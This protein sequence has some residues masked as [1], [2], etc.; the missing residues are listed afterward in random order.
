MD[1]LFLV[2]DQGCWIAYLEYLENYLGQNS[3]FFNLAFI[4]FKVINSGYRLDMQTSHH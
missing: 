1:R 3:Q 4:F 2:E